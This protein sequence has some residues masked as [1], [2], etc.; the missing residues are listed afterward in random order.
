LPID[1]FLEQIATSAWESG[2][3]IVIAEPGAG[4]STRVPGALLDHGANYGKRGRIV[5]L[6]PR[7]IAARGLAARIAAERGCRVGDEVGYQVRLERASGPGTRIEIVTEGILTSRL[8]SDAG[9]EGVDCVVLDEFHERSV[10]ADLALAMLREC[11]QSLR[12]DLAIVVMSATLDPAP[13]RQFLG[14]CPV[15]EVPGNLHP[16]EIVHS[17]AAR[18]DLIRAITRTVAEQL[19]HAG[20]GDIL[21]FLPGVREIESARAELRGVCRDRG[22]DLLPLHGRL[23]LSEQSQALRPSSR[24]RVVLSTNVA[25]TSLTL[26]GVRFVVDSGWARFATFDR[27]RGLDVLRMERISLASARQRAGRAGRVAPGRCIRLWSKAEEI[28][29]RPFEV[30]EVLRCDLAPTLLTLAGWGVADPDRFEWFQR[31]DPELVRSASH[32]LHWLGALDRGRLTPPGRVMA[33]LPVHPRIARFLVEFSGATEG[34]RELAATAAAILSERD[35][36][37]AGASSRTGP[38]DVLDRIHRL[39]RP[40]PSTDPAA[41]RAVEKL[42]AKL[43]HLIPAHSFPTNESGKTSR[44]DQDERIRRALFLAHPDRLCRRRDDDPNALACAD[45]SGARLSNESVVTRGELVVA[46]DTRLDERSARS[47]ALVRMASQVEAEWL[48][49]C[50]PALIREETELCWDDVQGRVVEKC[51]KVFLSLTL[52]ESL[53]RPADDERAAEVLADHLLTGDGGAV[54]SAEVMQLRARMELLARAVP[55][56]GLDSFSEAEFRAAVVDSCRGKV[57]ASEIRGSAICDAVRARLGH[58][59][60]R[61]LD[62]L[63]PETIQVPSGSRIRLDYRE[64]A[65]PVL[66][67][68]IQEIFGWTES[69]RVAGGRVPVVLHLLGP[70]YRPVQVTNDLGSFWKSTYF[71][72]RKDLRARYPRHSWPENPLEAPAQAKGGRTR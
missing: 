33:S 13:I 25:E 54:R 65:A 3:L 47:E 21:C 19:D 11:R 57:S 44:L 15:I 36:V 7:R 35:I 4:K 37:A 26:P 23:P 38:C 16:V 45:G 61:R 17:P 63:V 49:Q 12:P 53:R 30:P 18:G 28:S 10:H 31:P 56:D 64:R 60:A 2:V 72:V 67:V 5:V 55:G 1:P 51:R 40:D 14:G 39:A 58:L 62:E 42:A 50:F 69:P 68:R 24:R 71:Q 6:Q 48:E 32:L 22:I 41:V 34:L 66:A 29:F 70:N 8:L 20:E 52:E 27:R 59:R 43:R 9:L 46:L